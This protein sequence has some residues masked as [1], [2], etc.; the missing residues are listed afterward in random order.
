MEATEKLSSDVS[1]DNQK[2][3]EH[4]KLSHKYNSVDNFNTEQMEEFMEIMEDTKPNEK[5]TKAFA[6]YEERFGG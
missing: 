2:R 5:L 4:V 3:R 1:K 6:R